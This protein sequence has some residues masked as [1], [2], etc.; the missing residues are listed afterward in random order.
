MSDVTD[1]GF[2]RRR[3]DAQENGNDVWTVRDA[4]QDMI[5]S[6]DTGELDPDK[7]VLIT[8]TTYEDGSFDESFAL[9]GLRY[10][11]AIGM[12]EYRKHRWLQQMTGE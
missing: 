10:S 12:L 11:D 2:E 6:I 7:L 5:E 4:L 9:V 3:R 1:I 8:R